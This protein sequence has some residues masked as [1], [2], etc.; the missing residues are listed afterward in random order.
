MINT[1]SLNSVLERIRNEFEL[2]YIKKTKKLKTSLKDDQSIVTHI[3]HFVSQQIKD[4]LNNNN[5]LN[6][7]S[8]YCEEDHT[9]LNFPAL[10][11]DPI[12]G[13]QEL[14]QGIPECAMSLALMHDGALN[15]TPKR[16]SYGLIFN[17]FNGLCISTEDYNISYNIRAKR[18]FLVAL[19]SNTEYSKNPETFNSLLQEK[20]FVR[21]VGS[22]AYKL[23]LLAINA[24][25]FV[26]TFRDKHIWD[27]AA[28]TLVCRS[29]GIQLYNMDGEIKQLSTKL[30]KGPMIWCQ[31]E[32]YTKIR[33][34]VLKLIDYNSLDKS[35]G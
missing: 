17:P 15:N 22:I 33:A 9:D 14:A 10:V 20:I 13:T 16:P 5:H 4:F 2:V 21:P 8:F 35:K 1:N 31:S 18:E 24:G 6:Q 11:L 23:A 7:F 12:D 19:I 28:G 34:T 3:D 25:D 30:I 29:R 26:V 32:D 27:I